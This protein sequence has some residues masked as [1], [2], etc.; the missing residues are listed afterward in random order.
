MGKAGK[1]IRNLLLGKGTH[2]AIVGEGPKVIRR[3]SF[4]RSHKTI[5]SFDS[6]EHGHNHNFVIVPLLPSTNAA[7]TK[8]QAAYRSYLARRALRALRGLVK[9]QALVK[10]YLVR[11]QMNYV[12]RSM[13]AVMTIQVRA[14]IQRV[15]KT[16]QPR[17]ISYKQTSASDAQ[18]AQPTRENRV[19]HITREVLTRRISE[20]MDHRHTQRV[21]DYGCSRLS[22]SQQEYKL[23]PCPSL[24]ALSFTNSS[25]LS[26]DGR[27]ETMAPTNA[28]HFSI[29]HENKQFIPRLVNCPDHVTSDSSFLPNYMSNTKSSKAKARSHSE[30]KQ[31][32]LP[33]TDQKTDDHHQWTGKVAKIS[34]TG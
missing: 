20:R 31:R 19:D 7:A 14:R 8:I 24:S 29:W 27:Q 6:A 22:V 18:I 21:E 4:K 9:L 25:S 33:V 26:F 5:K 3:W 17:K 13:H 28:K 12:L 11:K 15:Q 10:G 30:P 32:P 34:A 23:N 1:W 2:E 16:D